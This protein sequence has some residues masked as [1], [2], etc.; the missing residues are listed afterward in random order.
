MKFLCLIPA[1]KNSKRLK[2]KNFQKIKGEM[3]IEK[4]LK[5]ASSI[6]EFDNVLLSSD[7]LNLQKMIKKKYPKIEFLKRPSK[8]AKNQTLMKRVIQHSINYSKK[9]GK[10]FNAIVLLQPTSPL[11][12]KST[13]LR[14]IKK[15][16]KLKPDF[17]A[18]IKIVKHNETPN[19]SFKCLDIQKI[20][21]INIPIKKYENNWYCLDG[22]TIFIFKVPGSY[23]MIGKGAFIKVEFPENI[24]IDT[25]EDLL[26]VKKFFK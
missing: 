4:T 14:S 18:S 10:N 8:L 5:L 7:N 15:F 3:L 20:K 26:L 21:K 22:G 23:S 2:N 24:D 12:K 25:K 16:K 13:I 6:R 17:L 1:R 19:M 11:R 9:K